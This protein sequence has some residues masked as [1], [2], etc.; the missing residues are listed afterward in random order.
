MP[1]VDKPQHVRATYQPHV[2]GEVSNGP[3]FGDAAFA[4]N[5]QDLVFIVATGGF[6][7]NYNSYEVS[8]TN[9][10]DIL[11]LTQGEGIIESFAVD[12]DG[13]VVFLR[14]GHGYSIDP[15]TH[16]VSEEAF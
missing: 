11:Q 13:T 7:F 4:R 1:Y 5:G 15:Q 6:D 8:T 2:K 10:G 3:I 14:N 12:R 9:G 16:A